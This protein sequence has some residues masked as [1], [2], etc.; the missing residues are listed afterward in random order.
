MSFSACTIMTMESVATIKVLQIQKDMMYLLNFIF[1]VSVLCY[2]CTAAT[3]TAAME[4]HGKT[5]WKFKDWCLFNFL[6]YVILSLLAVLF[7]LLISFSTVTKRHNEMG[8]LFLFL[9]WTI[10]L[11]IHKKKMIFCYSPEKTK[12]NKKKHTKNSTTPLMM[13]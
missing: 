12:Q 7:T 11:G 3:T 5:L 2:S 10:N 6:F 13:R 1:I 9:F 8:F 4:N